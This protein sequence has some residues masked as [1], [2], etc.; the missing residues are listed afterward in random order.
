MTSFLPRHIGTW[1]SDRQTMLDRVG[2][3][4]LEELTEA[5]LPAGLTRS[6]IEGLPEARSEQQVLDRLA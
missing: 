3:R 2:A 4:S 6:A 5:A 1:G